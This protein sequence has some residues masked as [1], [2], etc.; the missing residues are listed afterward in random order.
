MSPQTSRGKGS[1]SSGL[2]RSKLDHVTPLN[3]TRKPTGP[4]IGIDL[5]TTSLRVAVLERNKPVCIPFPGGATVMPALIALSTKGEIV[6]GAPAQAE[7]ATH[8]E[9]VVGD[10]RRLVGTPF[11]SSLVEALKTRYS[12]T[13]CEGLGGEVGIRFGSAS[14]APVELTALLLCEAK[15][16]AQ[17]YLKTPVQR[18]VLAVPGRFSSTQ[19]ELLRLAAARAGL[20][21]ERMVLEH[22]AAAWAAVGGK[23]PKTVAALDLGG[24]TFQISLVKISGGA[25]GVTANGSD[26]S[27]GGRDFDARLAAELLGSLPP[28]ARES[29]AK[30]AGARLRV[31]EAA[32]RVKIALSKATETQLR[33][34]LVAQVDMRSVDLEARVTRQRFEE[35]TLDLV[36]KTI[37][38]CDQFFERRGVLPGDV[39]ELLFVGGQAQMPLL[40]EKAEVLF[41]KVPQ[42]VEACEELVARGAA[43]EGAV[44]QPN[45]ASKAAPRA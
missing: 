14:L 12:C 31:L 39:D 41:W 16:A 36:E 17:N 45:A 23:D 2:I 27:L 11:R 8:P 4:V 37:A 42:R 20:H 13:F 43:L 5:G 1:A 21:V 33:I 44:F 18:I 26:P 29:T 15:E 32:E 10:V 34:P 25:I 28:K 30:N 9:N 7:R 40:R 19:K 35:L 22:Q 24:A 38:Q 6:A 3:L